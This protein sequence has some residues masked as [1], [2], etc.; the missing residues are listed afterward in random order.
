[1]VNLIMAI[2]SFYKGCNVSESNYIIKDIKMVDKADYLADMIAKWMRETKN[3]VWLIDDIPDKFKENYDLFEIAIERLEEAKALAAIKDRGKPHQFNRKSGLEIFGLS[4]SSLISDNNNIETDNPVN[5]I[6]KSLNNIFV[7]HGHND[8][9]R[10]SVKQ[11]LEDIGCHPI[12]LQDS[13]SYNK[14]LIE[15][16]ELY[17]KKVNYAVVLLT[18]DDMGGPINKPENQNPRPRQNVIFELGLFVGK[19]ERKNVFV[20]YEPG[21]EILSD[22]RGVMYI[23][24]DIDGLWSKTLAD[25]L[26]ASELSIDIDKANKRPIELYKRTTKGEVKVKPN[27][28]LN[29]SQKTNNPTIVAKNKEVIQEAY[30]LVKE[31]IDNLSNYNNIP[32][33]VISYDKWRKGNVLYLRKEIRRKLDSCFTSATFLDKPHENDSEEIKKHWVSQRKKILDTIKVLEDEADSVG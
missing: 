9:L 6:D 30:A 19:L 8:E 5:N 13:P 27:E 32:D 22:Y 1:M 2:V 4:K 16:L 7:V 14:T 23:K 20:L 12:I 10:K 31:L 29:D 24:I 21:V 18:A 28:G 11:L 15:K 26:N 25:E 33:I 3:K 17:A